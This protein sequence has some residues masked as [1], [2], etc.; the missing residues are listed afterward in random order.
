[1]LSAL[2]IGTTLKVN[3]FN[4]IAPEQE[5]LTSQIIMGKES[6]KNKMVG[7]YLKQC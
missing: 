4:M 3:I 7:F 2:I 5:D 1:M 6:R